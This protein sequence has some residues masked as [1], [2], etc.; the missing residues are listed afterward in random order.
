M[1]DDESKSDVENL[2]RIGVEELFQP[3]DSQWCNI[4]A[5]L[6]VG[7]TFSGGD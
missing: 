7:R 2:I 3:A 1:D 5:S 6:Q 4:N